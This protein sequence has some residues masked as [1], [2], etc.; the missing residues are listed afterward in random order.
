MANKANIADQML[1]TARSTHDPAFP[2]NWSPRDIDAAKRGW[3]DQARA[4][5]ESTAATFAAM[6]AEKEAVAKL[7]AEQRAALAWCRANGSPHL[8]SL[9]GGAA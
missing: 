5:R 7:E 6:R 4:I 3:G 9:N 1:T 2:A 8:P